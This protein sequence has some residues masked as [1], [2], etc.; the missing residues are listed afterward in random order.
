MT[1]KAALTVSA[2]DMALRSL[3]T[4]GMSY[5]DLVRETGT[6]LAAGA[7]PRELKERL[8]QHDSVE[9]LPEQIKIALQFFLDTWPSRPADRTA[10][11]AGEPHVASEADTIVLEDDAANDAAVPVPV[12]IPTSRGA[13]GEVLAGRFELKEMIGEGGMSRVYRALDTRAEAEAPLQEVA[14]KLLTRP[15][16]DDSAVY[17]A[18]ER[19]IDKL[20]QLSH[21]NIVRLYGCYRDG[22]TVFT[23]MELLKGPSLYTALRH[24]APIDAVAIVRQIA[25]ALVYAHRQDVVH[26]DLKPG[27]V[28]LEN[29]IVK[30]I[31]FGVAALLSRPRSALERREAAQSR[32]AVAVTPRYS[33]PQ[34]MARNA[35][36][37]AD[38]VYSLA[39]LAYEVST[40]VHPFDNGIEGQPLSFPPPER[41]GLTATQYRAVVNALQFERHNRTASVEAFLAEFE[42]PERREAPPRRSRAVTLTL[43]AAGVIAGL[44]GWQHHK[45]SRSPAPSA[46]VEVPAAPGKPG[47]ELR[48]CAECAVLKVLPPG[49]FRQGAAVE[50]AASGAA[51]K[52]AHLVSVAYALAVAVNDVTV[53]EFSAFVADTARDM[54]GCEIY[55]GAWR[56]QV[57]A[58]WNNPGFSQT[59][60]HPV[61]CVS[62]ADATAYAQWLSAKSGHRYRLPSAS[63]WEY[64]SRA[65]LEAPQPWE[66]TPARACAFANVAD[67][68]AARRYPGWSAFP[69]DD[70][71]VYTAPVG[72]YQANAF[73][74]N[75]MLG[76]VFQW[77]EDCWRGDYAQAPTDGSARQD[78]DCAEHEMR[79]GSWFSPAKFLNAA[80]RNRFATNYRTSSVG[81]RLVRRVDQ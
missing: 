30:V 14:L 71:Y 38:D 7:D 25:A 66:G 8:R 29:G 18:L 51:D 28:M 20:K 40:G 19:E 49:S 77:T 80:H 64:A 3:Q 15:I 24:A 76:N 72:S 36:T 63:E 78:G 39:C 22:A 5:G 9:P 67:E 21:P 61:T 70:G 32:Q 17:T 65:G 45:V 79:G 4:G 48:D 43:L 37:P 11:T 1:S 33:S 13:A 44:W 68:G 74:L 6:M 60:Q 16:A 2:F 55:D 35:P 62:W 47:T 31:D 46:A 12:D 69:C 57:D 53:G 75:D 34:L 54:A 81:F 23:V 58:S 10:P 52:P 73:G 27:N 50:D 26:G 42:R 59:A 41:S 56:V